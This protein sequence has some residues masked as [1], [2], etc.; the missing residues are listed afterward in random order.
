MLVLHALSNTKCYLSIMWQSKLQ[1]W[2]AVG[3]TMGSA[4]I[5]CIY[6]YIFFFY[7]FV[8][9]EMSSIKRLIYLGQ[10][11]AVALVEGSE[12]QM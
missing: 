10:S 8:E 5:V 11:L 4:L 7:F 1:G 3:V 9:G 12:P 2:Q 6:I